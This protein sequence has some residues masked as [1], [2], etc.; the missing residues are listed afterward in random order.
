VEKPE[1]IHIHGKGEFS[2]ERVQF[3]PAHPDEVVY[4]RDRRRDRGIIG[5]AFR[6]RLADGK[7]GTLSGIHGIYQILFYF[8][9]ILFTDFSGKDYDLRGANLGFAADTGS[10]ALRAAR[11]ASGDEGE[12]LLRGIRPLVVLTGKVLLDHGDILPAAG[13]I[14]VIADIALGFT[15]NPGH[16]FV[17]GLLVYTGNVITIQ[18]AHRSKAG[19]AEEMGQFSEDAVGLIPETGLSFNI[20]TIHMRLLYGYGPINAISAV[21][22]TG[23]QHYN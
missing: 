14:I 18:A 3:F 8:I 12:A 22:R 17:E 6:F 7:Q 4:N 10:A 20:Y 21:V 23:R 11:S 19:N 5:F 2:I 16:R 1:I 15:E 9:N 13:K